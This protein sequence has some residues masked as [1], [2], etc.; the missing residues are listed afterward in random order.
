MSC[1]LVI[2]DDRA[3]TDM[4]KALLEP[5]AFRVITAH[6]V[7]EGIEA[8]QKREPDLII[9]DLNMPGNDDAQICRLI[10]DFSRAPLLVLSASNKPGAA[11]KAL[12]GGADDYMLKPVA[13]G[14]LVAHINNLLRRARAEYKARAAQLNA[15]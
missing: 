12:D 1:V 5:K 3:M 2:D 14:V 9:L 15:L 13:S 6:H 4:L 11:T 8:I 10:R 7:Q